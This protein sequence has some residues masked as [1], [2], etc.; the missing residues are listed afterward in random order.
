MSLPPTSG[1]KGSMRS[2]FFQPEPKHI[3]RMERNSRSPGPFDLNIK[4]D[5]D[6]KGGPTRGWFVVSLL[7]RR[8]A[9]LGGRGPS[10]KMILISVHVSYT[11]A[12]ELINAET[13]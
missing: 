3:F 1:G 12:I 8:L 10:E 5:P 13:N 2:P 11:G 6:G 9:V 4:A 7:Q